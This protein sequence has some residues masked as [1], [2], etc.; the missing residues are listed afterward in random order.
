MYTVYGIYL[1][2][3]DQPLYIGRTALF[4]SRCYTHFSEAPR[5][6]RKCLEA[7]LF[8]DSTFELKNLVMQ[9]ARL[10]DI[11]VE[12]HPIAVFAESHLAR[13]AESRQIDFQ[14][15]PLN[16]HTPKSQWHRKA[17]DFPFA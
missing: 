12:I 6:L 11:E 16:T 5:H 17:L 2:G 13:R 10:G 14:R 7:G 3:S 15:P 9:M 1:K 4:A 8:L